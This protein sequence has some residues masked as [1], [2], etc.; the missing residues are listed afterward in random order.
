[1]P[2]PPVAYTNLDTFLANHPTGQRL[3]EAASAAETAAQVAESAKEQAQDILAVLPSEV[4]QELDE[5]VP[6]LI[7]QQVV[8]KVDP[9]VL[10]AQ[11][12]Q[13]AAQQA[14]DQVDADA[15]AVEL[16]RQDADG[17]AT[18]ARLDADRAEA[19]A[20][21]LQTAVVKVNSFS[22]R[23]GA[24]ETRFPALREADPNRL[25]PEYGDDGR[26]IAWTD[27]VRGRVF[28]GLALW[29][30]PREAA[31][32]P[33]FPDDNG[34]SP[35]W[36]DRAGNLGA[37]GMAVNWVSVA[38]DPSIRDATVKPLVVTE[39][40]QTVLGYHYRTGAVD[41]IPTDETRLRCLPPPLALSADTLAATFGFNEVYDPRPISLTIGQFLAPFEG[42]TRA[43]LIRTDVPAQLAVE[44][45][46]GRYE[47]II[48]QG[49]SLSD[50][51]TAGISHGMVA[52]PTPRAPHHGMMFNTDIKAPSPDLLN[53]DAVTDFLPARESFYSLRNDTQGTTMMDTIHAMGAAAGVQRRGVI[54]QTCGHGGRGI[55]QI[56]KNPPDAQVAYANTLLTAQAAKKVAAKYGK[57]IVIRAVPLTHGEAD[58]S[59]TSR[60]TYLAAMRQLLNDNN[61]DL[62]PVTGQA[63]P[64]VMILDQLSAATNATGASEI[65]LAQLDAVETWPTEFFPSTPKY[66]FQGAYGFVSTRHL[67]P[68]GYALLGEYNGRVW[69]HLFQTGEGWTATRPRAVSRQGAVIDIQF[70][71][72]KP[73]L[74]LDTT[75]LSA[76]VNSGFGYTDDAGGPTIQSV[77]VVDNDV[78]RVTLTGEPLGASPRISYALTGGQV[79]PAAP[80][81]T[82]R[83]ATWGNLRDSDPQESRAIPGLPLRNWSWTF[84][85]SV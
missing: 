47:L 9:K 33:L 32:I 85:R 77:A 80:D 79:L 68:P 43:F 75:T 27:P 4:Q 14:A 58:A 72:P 34:R 37:W 35:V 52:S 69:H 1:M 45:V 26:T 41:L 49:Q 53:V 12:A 62:R 82:M 17:K 65:A 25:Y 42:Q 67:W 13:D 81:G 5:R 38:P 74:V 51:G 78:V 7:D 31:L 28:A 61:A 57:S 15:Q 40:G 8:S 10:A 66:F 46:L 2:S 19:A 6:P 21:P 83:S 44:A 30:L 84:E 39:S 60:A 73:P 55:A 59:S 18:A 24:L 76:A 11:A 22:P 23:V 54:Y 64:I 70:W 48:H 56:S 29:G 3:E 20:A 16:S 36:A 71:V 63:E 50:G